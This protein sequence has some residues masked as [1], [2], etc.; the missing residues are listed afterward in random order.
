MLCRAAF[1]FCL[2][3]VLLAGRPAAAQTPPVNAP[4][5]RKLNFDNPNRIPGRYMV[6]FKS[7]AQLSTLRAAELRG[8]ESPGLMPITREDVANLADALARR[9]RATLTHTFRN[10]ARAFALRDV[11]EAA[12]AD[13]LRDPRVD[14]IEAVMRVQMATTQGS[15]SNPAP[16]HLDR[17][18]QRL[19]PMDGTYTY[20]FVGSGVRVYVLDTGLWY[21]HNEFQGRADNEVW[22]CVV[23][24][25]FQQSCRSKDTSDGNI[26]CRGH[27][28]QV[29]GIIGSATYGVAKG[30][31]LRGVIVT[32]SANDGLNCSDAG[33]TADATSG[34]DFVEDAAQLASDT[35]VVNYSAHVL[36]VS[37]T[38]ESAIRG[39]INDG[40]VVVVS[41][42][43]QN[44]NA[45]DFTPMRMPEVIAVGATTLADARTSTSGFG[46]CIDV[47]A[48]G[49]NMSSTNR[50]G[51]NDTAHGLS[52]TSYAAPVVTGIV[53]LYLQQ[54]PTA[55][56]AQVRTA[57]VNGATSGI[58][59]GIGPG[60][61]NLLAN[62]G[63]T[64]G[65]APPGHLT[66]QRM[67]AVLGIINHLLLTD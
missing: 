11:T 39:A 36:G 53:A 48:P 29:A 2:A 12:L 61:P 56:P 65:E 47:F 57:I 30:V 67:R 16:W 4:L 59:T 35:L 44:L 41:T 32:H 6:G 25:G 64:T 54:F 27:G 42:G 5:A 24:S 38:L 26:D 50:G 22:D 45:C 34:F 1:L 63:G 37:S 58:L 10:S 19:L 3:V 7:D 14:Y 9:T 52:G 21:T 13:L 33:D 8:V 15:P 66:Q 46:P 51:N 49:I 23:P 62:M 40:V 20:G 55:T 43:N 60:S 17:I 18:D 31:Q 28:T